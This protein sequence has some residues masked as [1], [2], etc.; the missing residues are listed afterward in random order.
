MKLILISCTVE[1]V[2]GSPRVL[3]PHFGSYIQYRI[4]RIN[5]RLLRSLSRQGPALEH[6]GQATG[7]QPRTSLDPVTRETG[8]PTLVSCQIAKPG[9]TKEGGSRDIKRKCFLKQ[10]ILN[11]IEI[12]GIGE[13]TGWFWD[14]IHEGD[15]RLSEFL[16]WALP[17]KRHKTGQAEWDMEMKARDGQW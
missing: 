16:S 6:S 17:Q 3:K 14:S 7:K 11:F 4:T 12:R 15:L 10:Q 9:F 1:R 8:M 2:L 13:R 5:K